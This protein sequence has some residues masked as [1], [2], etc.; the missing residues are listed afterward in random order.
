MDSTIEIFHAIHEHIC[1]TTMTYIK[2]CSSQR[3]PMKNEVFV[4]CSVVG[5]KFETVAIMITDKS[6]NH[7]LIARR[8]PKKIRNKKNCLT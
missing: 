6:S 2:S 4:Q 3:I 1:N 5:A 8:L 7:F